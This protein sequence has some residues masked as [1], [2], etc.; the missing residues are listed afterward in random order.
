MNFWRR[1]LGRQPSAANVSLPTAGPSSEGRGVASTARDNASGKAPEIDA[2]WREFFDNAP[3]HESARGPFLAFVGSWP[4]GIDPKQFSPANWHAIVQR[5]RHH[6]SM[7]YPIAGFGDGED[8]PRPDYRMV[9]GKVARASNPFIDML[10]CQVL[11]RGMPANAE[12]HV[13]TWRLIERYAAW[14]LAKL[15][16]LLP[17]FEDASQGAASGK[18][19]ILVIEDMLI[20]VYKGVE[21]ALFGAYEDLPEGGRLS[22]DIMERKLRS[23]LGSPTT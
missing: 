12:P 19:A 4:N 10:I 9:D 7:P 18:A 20:Q 15:L 1:L 11:P 6:L 8:A 13:L 21:N 3:V 17:R 22:D 16:F 2:Q 23:V 14:P 5:V